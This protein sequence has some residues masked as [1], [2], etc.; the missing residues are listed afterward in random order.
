MFA[1]ALGSALGTL[2]RR[3]SWAIVGTIL[4]FGVVSLTMTTAVR[5]NLA[6]K[7]FVANSQGYPSSSSL[8]MSVGGEPWRLGYGYQ[9]APGSHHPTDVSA[10]TLGRHCEKLNADYYS[11]ITHNHLQFGSFYQPASNYWTLQWK[12]SAIYLIASA[13]LLI[14]G[15]WLVRRWRA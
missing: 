10:A 15:M 12:E 6:P 1:F 4:V 13:S 5:P 11:C 9:F 7:T 8:A 2:L 14:F 3:V